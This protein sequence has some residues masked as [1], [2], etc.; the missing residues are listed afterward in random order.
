MGESTDDLASSTSKLREEVKALSGVDIM[1]DNNT[2]KSTAEIIKEIGAVYDKLSDVSK[3]SLLEKL[4]GKTRASTVAGLLENYQVI[5]DV[6]NSAQGADGSAQ[7]ENE[8]YLDSINGKLA[9]LKNSSQE[10]WYT[11]LSS[12]TVK[13]AISALTTVLNLINDIVK[14]AGSFNIIIASAATA[15]DAVVRKKTGGGRANKFALIEICLQCV[16]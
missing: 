15:L 13:G 16:A 7:K 11:F 9:Q 3:A 12:D 2:Y 8:R 4:A 6:I 10:F 5:D 14:S 1:A